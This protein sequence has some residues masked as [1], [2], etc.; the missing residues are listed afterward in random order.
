MTIFLIWYL[1][2]FLPL[3]SSLLGFHPSWN[4]VYV[5]HPAQRRCIYHQTVSHSPRDPCLSAIYGRSQ[6][7]MR[8]NDLD[9]LVVHF[10]HQFL[11]P[12]SVSMQHVSHSSSLWAAVL[13]PFG[14]LELLEINLIR[15]PLG[16]GV[17]PLPEGA[18]ELSLPPSSSS[19]SSACAAISS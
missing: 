16:C 14:S 7:P 11:H 3:A 18:T 8:S 5:T 13:P 4:N 12:L 9:A 15:V 17:P 1:I 19:W 10:P 6:E 2:S